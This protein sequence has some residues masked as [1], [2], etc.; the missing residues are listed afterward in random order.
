MAARKILRALGTLLV[1][2]GAFLVA[3]A[4]W[5]AS[6]GT[7]IAIFLAWVC[8]IAGLMFA[9]WGVLLRWSRSA[10]GCFT[11][12]ALS[13]TSAGIALVLTLSGHFDAL[14]V[15]FALVGLVPLAIGLGL[16]LWRLR[17]RAPA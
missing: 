4:C 1:T 2:W 16:G 7:T 10:A 12:A 6:D 15:P 11:G 5:L 8:T 14:L 3:L 13:A 9:S 17:P